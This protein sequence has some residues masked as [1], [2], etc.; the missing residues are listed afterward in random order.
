[1][2]SDNDLDVVKLWSGVEGIV[3]AARAARAAGH[4]GHQ[5]PR[6]EGLTSAGLQA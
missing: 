3:F 2:H 6:A 5:P 1:M 4:E